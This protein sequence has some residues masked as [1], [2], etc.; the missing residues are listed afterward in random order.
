MYTV[1]VTLI[2]LSFSANIPLLCLAPIFVILPVFRRITYYRYSIAKISSYLI[3]FYENE[4][5]GI[6]WEILRQKVC[7][8]DQ[9]QIS[10]KYYEPIFLQAICLFLYCMSSDFLLISEIF[11]FVC[12]VISTIFLFSY[13]IQINSILNMKSKLIDKFK[14]LKEI[15]ASGEEK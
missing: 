11:I 12:A 4:D 5:Y 10:L 15:E 1:S 14:Q 2:T 9:N 8:D 3:V 7:D 13:T 6:S